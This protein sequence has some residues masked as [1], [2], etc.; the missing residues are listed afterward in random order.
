MHRSHKLHLI[1]R[2]LH[3]VRF[4]FE[5]K[6]QTYAFTL[7]SSLVARVLHATVQA[8]GLSFSFEDHQLVEKN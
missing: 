2:L 6:S 5:L 7:S 8:Y 3:Q 1:F 4:T